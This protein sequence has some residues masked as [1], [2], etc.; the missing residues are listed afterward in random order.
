MPKDQVDPSEVFDSFIEQFVRAVGGGFRMI[1]E[2]VFE[3]EGEAVSRKTE[4]VSDA[5]TEAVSEASPTK[6]VVALMKSFADL[7]DQL[8][9]LDRRGY[10]LEQIITLHGVGYVI[11]VRRDKKRSCQC[12]R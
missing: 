9:E 11:G 3:E 5:P 8:N 12:Q 7:E 10:D 6:Y 2:A 4:E 1:S